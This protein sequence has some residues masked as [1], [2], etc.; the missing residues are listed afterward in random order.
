MASTIQKDFYLFSRDGV[1][2][3]Q[4]RDPVT[5]N[6]LS[7]KST[8]LRNRTLADR[9]AKAEYERRCSEVGK[10]DLTL[11]EYAQRFYIDGCPH[12]AARKA[13]GETF[14]VKTRMDYRHR[15]EAYLL[16]DPICQK[17]LCDITRPDTL[18]LREYSSFSL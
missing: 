4:F 2:Y 16:P 11:G 6:M 10:S 13:E 15:L 18:G 8:G 1:Y 17:R 3:V 7:K 12:E 5:R 14:G 9:W